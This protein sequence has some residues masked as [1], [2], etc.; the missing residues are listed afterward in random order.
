MTDSLWER[1]PAWRLCTGQVTVNLVES[2]TIAGLAY[3]GLLSCF[4]RA[5]EVTNHCDCVL[6]MPSVCYQGPFLTRKSGAFTTCSII[7]A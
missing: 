6:L 4:V 7:A 2:R 3:V 1:P 5:N